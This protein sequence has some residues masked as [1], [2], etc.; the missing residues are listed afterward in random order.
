MNLTS[1]QTNTKPIP[2]LSLSNIFAEQHT[3]LK[4]PGRKAGAF[5]CLGAPR[6][7]GFSRFP[8]KRSSEFKGNGTSPVLLAKTLPVLSTFFQFQIFFLLPSIP[9]VNS[10]RFPLGSVMAGRAFL[11][12]G[13]RKEQPF[14]NVKQLLFIYEC[15]WF[16]YFIVTEPQDN[17]LKLPDYTFHICTV[18]TVFTANTTSDPTFFMSIP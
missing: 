3:H 5:E 11:L 17:L 4:S 15:E 8:F 9:A 13:K 10:L 16:R 12:M 1:S 18:T 6:P 14:L 7:A 2:L